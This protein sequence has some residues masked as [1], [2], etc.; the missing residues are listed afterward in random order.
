[1]HIIIG[2]WQMSDAQLHP[3]NF[4]ILIAASRALGGIIQ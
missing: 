2:V 3:V 1:M 4:K